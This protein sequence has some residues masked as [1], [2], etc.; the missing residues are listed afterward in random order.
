MT[1]K[2]TETTTEKANDLKLSR[3]NLVQLGLGAAA[4]VT[5]AGITLASPARTIVTGPGP[6]CV[7]AAAWRLCWRLSAGPAQANNTSTRPQR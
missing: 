1:E 2:T 7:L 5:T 3:R 6:R 4:A